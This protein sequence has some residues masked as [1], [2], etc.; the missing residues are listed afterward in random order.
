MDTLSDCLSHVSYDLPIYDHVDHILELPPELLVYI[1]VFL[2]G[3]QISKL[4]RVCKKFYSIIHHED[5]S[6]RKYLKKTKRK[7]IPS[8]EQRQN[9]RRLSLNLATIC[10]PTTS[11]IIGYDFWILLSEIHFKDETLFR[12]KTYLSPIQ[13]RI[14]YLYYYKATLLNDKY[15]LEKALRSLEDI[16]TSH[17]YFNEVCIFCPH[18]MY[19]YYMIYRIDRDYALMDMKFHAFNQL[20][21]NVDTQG[22]PLIQFFNEKVYNS[23]NDNNPLKMIA[24]VKLASKDVLK[25]NVGNISEE[26]LS[27]K[28]T[29]TTLEE[30]TSNSA[31]SGSNSSTINTTTTNELSM[32]SFI[33]QMQSNLSNNPNTIPSAPTS[34]SSTTTLSTT[35][36]QH[37][38]HT[39]YEA[40]DLSSEESKKY[41]TLLNTIYKNWLEKWKNTI[42]EKPYY[43]SV[44]NNYSKIELDIVKTKHGFSFG[45]DL[46]YAN[47]WI[48][49]EEAYVHLL[50]HGIHN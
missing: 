31:I 13:P 24:I 16:I 14:F 29:S 22:V 48:K 39:K 49:R 38:H 23:G 33:S 19:Y 41:L 45:N 18:L 17:P 25:K 34:S 40:L 42:N 2:N 47:G 27:N 30:Q 3:G 10:A 35:A 11:R 32:L 44:F 12:K 5:E 15:Q 21:F 7:K 6:E 37:H 36:T 1:F 20:G 8:K 50:Q 43:R 46:R 26:S 28:L 4:E 9:Q